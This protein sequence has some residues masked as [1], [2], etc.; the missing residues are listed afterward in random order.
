MTLGFIQL[1]Y[2]ECIFVR[3]EPTSNIPSILAI[4]VDDIVLLTKTQTQMNQIKDALG[5]EFKTVQLGRLN[6]ILGIKVQWQNN[7]VLIEQEKFVKD[8]LTKFGLSELKSKSTP[9]VT[10]ENLVEATE[11]DQ[12]IDKNLYRQLVGTLVYLSTCTRPDI[13][14]AVNVAARFCEK[15]TK[16][17]MTAVHRIFAY[18]AHT[19]NYG[20]C[21]QKGN[22][23]KS[24]NYMV[25]CFTD[26]DWATDPD[27]RK[28]VT[29]T[30]IKIGTAVV[31]WRS[32]RQQCISLSTV[33]SEFV[34]A[35]ESVQIATQINGIINEILEHETSINLFTDNMGAMQLINTGNFSKRTKHI[36][37][38]YRYIC[39]EKEKGNIVVQYVPTETNLADIFTKALD[40]QA[41]KRLRGEI[42]ISKPF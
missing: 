37:L 34:A 31:A 20:L 18:L 19:A 11:N 17:H 13:S 22:D 41:F 14:F 27:T 42:G 1:Q 23:F 28:S 29:G 35:S 5:S 6:Y 16:Q 24:E 3:R 9:M 32:S 38:R 7:K 12:I 25:S 36:D 21:F 39:L 8:S 33:Q 26:S 2:D 30:T 15:P 40:E 4:Y 10:R